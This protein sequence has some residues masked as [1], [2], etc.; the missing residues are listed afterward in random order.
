[1]SGQKGCS[2]LA[3]T[4]AISA[5]PRPPLWRL[6]G[7]AKRG[8]TPSAPAV[9]QGPNGIH[10]GERL[11]LASRIEA[12]AGSWLGPSRSRAK[13]Q[14]RWRVAVIARHRRRVSSGEDRTPG[15]PA[16]VRLPIFSNRLSVRLVATGAGLL[17]CGSLLRGGWLRCCC[18]LGTYLPGAFFRR[19]YAQLA[20]C[21]MT[22]AGCG[23]SDSSKRTSKSAS[24]PG[25][26]RGR[27][28]VPMTW[29]VI[30]QALCHQ[31]SCHKN[32]TF[33]CPADCLAAMVPPALPSRPTRSRS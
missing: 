20:R 25:I 16:V 2:K 11:A 15:E 33:R 9:R 32:S 28:K 30:P 4:V 29:R 3:R 24:T 31:T 13:P 5:R 18:S 8:C 7:V 10:L 21:N 19:I 26:S 14:G 22:N 23:H 1:M 27:Y 12:V 6:H 17:Q